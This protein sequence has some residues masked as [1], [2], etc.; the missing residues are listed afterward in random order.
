MIFEPDSIIVFNI[1]LS[2]DSYFESDI[3]RLHDSI[4]DID[5]KCQCDSIVVFDINL[6]IDSYFKFD[7]N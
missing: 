7:I 3:N 4:A 2:I 6:S 1:N 5:I